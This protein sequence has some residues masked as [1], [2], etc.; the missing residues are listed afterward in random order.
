MH[1]FIHLALAS[2]K[3][4]RLFEHKGVDASTYKTR[5]HVFSQP[6]EA[7]LES[8]T[9]LQHYYATEN[10]RMAKQNPLPEHLYTLANPYTSLGTSD[11]SS[12]LSSGISVTSAGPPFFLPPRVGSFRV[13]GFCGTFA[14]AL[15]VSCVTARA[16]AGVG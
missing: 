14:A 3:R 8:T 16:A 13:A 7:A 11:S 15:L 12:S 9:L 6:Y 2:Q 5:Y 10:T 1:T 4:L